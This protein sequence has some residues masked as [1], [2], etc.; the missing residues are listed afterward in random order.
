MA[1]LDNLAVSAPTRAVMPEPEVQTVTRGEPEYPRS[2][3]RLARPPARIWFRGRL[4]GAG[5]A[6]SVDRCIAVVG[7]RAATARALDRTRQIAF[8]L[9]RAGYQ[10]V[11]GGAYGVDAAAHE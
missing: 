10:I 2:L 4:P 8:Q 5:T 3:E 11:S 6:T 9:G 7:A 1:V